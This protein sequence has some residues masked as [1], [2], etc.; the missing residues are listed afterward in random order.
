MR[1]QSSQP[2]SFLARTLIFPLFLLT[3]SCNHEEVLITDKKSAA[4]LEAPVKQISHPPEQKKLGLVSLFN[5][6]EEGFNLEL[7]EDFNKKLLSSCNFPDG[8]GEYSRYKALYLLL[9][10]FNKNLDQWTP[11]QVEIILRFNADLLSDRRLDFLSGEESVAR[12][13]NSTNEL[14]KGVNKGAF[15]TEAVANA[16]S[17]SHNVYNK[18]VKGMGLKDYARLVM[19]NGKEGLKQKIRKEFPTEEFVDLMLDDAI[20]HKVIKDL[21]RKGIR[22]KLL[23]DTRGG[24]EIAPDSFVE[25]IIR[26]FLSPRREEYVTLERPSFAK[27]PDE[28]Y[29]T[30]KLYQAYIAPIQQMIQK[31]GVEAIFN[32]PE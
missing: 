3:N 16:V 28:L 30:A 29:F 22:K 26:E 18:H 10:S 9:E 21:E 6:V 13:I 8:R 12:V 5:S 17:R 25:N 23:R 20:K 11:E 32:P 2:K 24:K 1:L 19:P 7:E 4:E 14:I 31:P 27:K 15:S